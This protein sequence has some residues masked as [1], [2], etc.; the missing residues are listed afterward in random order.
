MAHG[1]RKKQPYRVT[2]QDGAPFAFA[3]LWERWRPKGTP[4]SE[5]ETLETFTIL[6]TD[7]APSIHHIH[8]RMPV[9]LSRDQWAVWLDPEHQDA[10]A[11]LQPFA[12]D[13]L[14]AFPVTPRVGSV[15][16]DDPSLLEPHKPDVSEEAPPPKPKQ[17]SLF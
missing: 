13:R 7:A 15:K 1:G 16:N 3:G 6:T 9:M 14:T 8:H 11:L 10:A 17:G 5:D 2:T 12:D 4:S